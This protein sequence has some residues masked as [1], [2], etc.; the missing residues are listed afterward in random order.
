[1]DP[2]GAA[3]TTLDHTIS[4]HYSVLVTGPLLASIWCSR[5]PFLFLPFP[6]FQLYEQKTLFQ[7]DCSLTL[8]LDLETYPNPVLDHFVR[9]S[10]TSSTPNVSANSRAVSAKLWDRGRTHACTPLPDRSLMQHEQRQAER[11]GTRTSR[12]F[13]GQ[14]MYGS[15][16]L[17]RWNAKGK[18]VDK[19]WY[20]VSKVILIT[21]QTMYVIPLINTFSLHEP[22]RTPTQGDQHVFFLCKT[23]PAVSVVSKH[24]SRS[25]LG[26]VFRFRFRFRFLTLRFRS[27]LPNA[28]QCCDSLEHTLVYRT[29]VCAAPVRRSAQT[30]IRAPAGNASYRPAHTIR[31]HPPPR[32]TRFLHLLLSITHPTRA[33][34]SARRPRRGC[35]SSSSDDTRRP[36]RR[37]RGTRRR[38]A[39]GGRR[40]RRRACGCRPG[41]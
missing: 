6:S 22:R 24:P 21:L 10:A 18:S 7:C 39:W 41:P 8:S 4:C 13:G 33:T 37:R 12:P 28:V 26:G 5:S 15:A 16:C 31:A 23:P 3:G 32:A 1:M 34:S 25:S 14:V 30:A 11:G 36:R 29:E 27:A 20:L 2:S 40:G 9:L 38:S 35:G 19:T 17:T